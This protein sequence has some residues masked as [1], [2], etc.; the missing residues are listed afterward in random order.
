MPANPPLIDTTGAKDGMRAAKWNETAVF[1]ITDAVVG[2]INIL[3]GDK[4]DISALT[5]R[6]LT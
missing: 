1:V 3:V 4:F 5:S 2:V 6:S